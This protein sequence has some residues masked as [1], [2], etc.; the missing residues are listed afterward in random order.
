MALALID[1]LSNATATLR[2]AMQDADLSAMD[3][4]MARF[5]TAVE[6]VQAV[7]AWRADGELKDL[8]KSVIE[9]LEASRRLA[10]LMGDMAGQMHMAFASR[11]PDAQQTLYQRPR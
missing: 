2:K 8:I 5:G 3:A 10:C 7:G 9:E 11:N 4:A 6:A 1:D